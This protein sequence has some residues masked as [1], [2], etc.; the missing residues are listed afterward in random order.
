M[1][2][3]I[4]ALFALSF[5]HI[6]TAQ[7][8]TP[9]IRI[10]DAPHT[11]YDGEFRNNE[12]AASLLPNGKLG[13]LVFGITSTQS[14]F[15]IDAS[16]VA[17]IEDMADG[18]T[19]AK[20]KDP[21][22]EQTARNW[23]SRLKNVVRSNNVVAL[24]Y[25][26]PDEKLLKKIAP[27]E[28]RFYSSF[29]QDKLQK[30]LGRAVSAQNGWSKGTSRL[31]DAFIENYTKN[32][33]TLTGLSTVIDSADI[34]EMR[35]R[36]AI[37]MNPLLGRDDRTYFSYN[38]EI[39]VDALAN[40]LKVVSGRYQITSESAKLPITLVNNFDTASVVNISLIPMNSRIRVQN[41]NNITIAAKSR[42][43]ILVPVEVIAPGTT[44]VFAQFM[45]NKGQLVGKVSKLNLTATIID[46]R[47]AWFTTAAAVLLF[48]GAVTQSVRRIR[49]A[50]K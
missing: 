28:L 20:K 37:V 46:S 1:K 47:V 7:A 12:L 9:V 30:T 29:A 22:G 15:V 49:R 21:A 38:Q 41:L 16:L 10:V 48:L 18:Y 23:L 32:R 11:N 8:D 35:A 5:L 27:G 26:N 50:R 39:A 3:L 40:R 31:N 2:K 33:R 42:Q 43:Q 36:L 44:L 4:V 14:T 19:Y 17:E 34:T 13:K 6:P 45:N 25:G 24:P